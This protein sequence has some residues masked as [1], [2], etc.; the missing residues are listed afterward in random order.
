MRI[1]E[2]A[3]PIEESTAVARGLPAFEIGGPRLRTRLTP[4][5]RD[6]VVERAGQVSDWLKGTP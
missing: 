1:G 4:I 5:V 2:M 3:Q 6:G